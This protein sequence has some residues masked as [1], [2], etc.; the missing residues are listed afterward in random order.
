MSAGGSD[1]VRETVQDVVTSSNIVELIAAFDQRIAHLSFSEIA[2]GALRFMSEKMGIAR[3][4]VALLNEVDRTFRIFDSTREV[5]GVESGAVVP[6]SAA[7]LGTTVERGESVYRPN[8]DDWAHDNPV[9]KALIAAGLH[10][11]FSTPLV[12]AG[13]C[14]GTLNAAAITVDGIDPVTRRLV[15]LLAP[16]LAFAIHTGIVH[17]QLRESEARFRDVFSTVGDGILVA[18]TT[19]RRLLMANPAVC[20]MLGRSADELLGLTI[21]VIHPAERLEEVVQTFVDMVEGR[22]DHSMDVPILRADGTVFFADVAARSTRLS[23][24]PSVVGVFR[25]ASSRRERE[26]EQVQIQKLESIRTLAAGIAHDFNN[27]LT[28]LVGNMSL[29]QPQLSPGSD[30][31]ESL[32][33]AQRA[34]MRA[35]ALTRQ[36]LTFAKGGSPIRQV[37]DLVP[38]VRDSAN[39]AC[40]GT[41][42]RCSV[43][44]PEHRILVLGDDGQLA[45]VVQN[46]VRNAVDAMPGGGT[47]RVEVKV[48]PAGNGNSGP[49]ACL[50]V[51]DHGQ[52]IAPELLDRIF[53]PFFTTKSSGS[54]LGLA[55]AYSVVQSHGGRIHVTSKLG[56]GTT[57][58]VLL[59][60]TDQAN[61]GTAAACA[62]APGQGRILVMDD[63]AIIRTV[64]ERILAK[65]GYRAHVVTN[66][67]EAIDA[68][69]E[70]M[71]IGEPFEAAV[72]DL[73]VPGAMGGREAAV[74]I[75]AI[76]PDAKLIVSS[77]YSDEAVMSEYA[78]H[79][80]LA[81]LPKPYNTSQLLATVAK[82][83]HTELG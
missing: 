20:N 81:V 21:D 4:S 33:E 63:Q 28:G 52:G 14:I 69:R 48:S 34:A 16:R 19:N 1:Q 10:A 80:F 74:G 5:R 38:I 50:D 83:L 56:V 82:V 30:A 26:Q 35:T 11:T 66:G 65:A 57:F 9:D 61:A 24:Q 42:V 49:E 73:T 46:L 75:L 13:Q 77:G 51:V 6:F 15:E 8:L 79:G 37:T 36:L 70:A 58:Q 64:A 29:V 62:T 7:S 43:Q 71:E 68:Y 54:G 53:V 67:E 41:N 59:P 22:I 23:G 55:V 3:A 45:Q 25:D 31:W 18:N 2:R 32:E 72:L 12:C 39:L 47:V 17:D 78:E 44:L 76:D 60:V 27:L 40:A